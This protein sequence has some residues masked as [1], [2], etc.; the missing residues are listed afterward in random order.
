MSLDKS[1][2]RKEYRI[3]R[4]AFSEK[5]VQ[6]KSGQIFLM[7]K[8][9]L[10]EKPEIKHVHIFLPISDQN[11]VNTFLIRDYLFEKR[12]KVYTSIIPEGK[13]ILETVLIDFNTQYEIDSWG[14]PVPIHSE[15]VDPIDIELVLIPL[16]AFDLKGNRIGYGKGFYDQFLASLNPTVMKTGLS[17][18]PPI[19][20]I[21]AEKHDIPLDYCITTEKV[22]TF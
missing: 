4:K 16:L 3:K 8:N 13:S 9:W 1:Q 6:L 17:F 12:I 22:F 19:K 7:F 18:F 10:K 2:L 15:I 20:S 5:E 14:I 11:E 21:S